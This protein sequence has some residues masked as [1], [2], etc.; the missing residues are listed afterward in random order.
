M[1]PPLV[2]PLAGPIPGRQRSTAWRFERFPAFTPGEILRLPR[3]RGGGLRRSRGRLRGGDHDPRRER[4]VL[5]H[6][7]ANDVV[8]CLAET[9]RRQTDLFFVAQRD[10]P[11][12]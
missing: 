3:R 6:R 8:T 5:D 9:A 11:A 7:E 2:L 1:T 12:H 10:A 4:D